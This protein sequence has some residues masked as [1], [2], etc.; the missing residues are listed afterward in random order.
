MMR[1]ATYAIASRMTRSTGT[2]GARRN[3]SLTAMAIMNAAATPYAKRA[4]GRSGDRSKIESF[5]G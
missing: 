2:P 5:S 1:I 4:T 3:S